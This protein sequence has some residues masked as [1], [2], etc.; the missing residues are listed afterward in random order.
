MVFIVNK[1]H[2]N[3]FIFNGAV[4]LDCISFYNVR[5]LC[6][7]PFKSFFLMSQADCCDKI[8]TSIGQHSHINSYSI[9]HRSVLTA[10]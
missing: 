7:L 6:L 3:S 9:D 8:C 1:I 5:D 2:T 4:V 10:C